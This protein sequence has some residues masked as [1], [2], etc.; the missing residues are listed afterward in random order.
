MKCG[1]NMSSGNVPL[2]SRSEKVQQNENKNRPVVK[3]IL[4]I[5][6]IFF[7]CA[8]GYLTYLYV[9]YDNMLDD[10]TSGTEENVPAAHM[11]KSKPL[12]ILLLGLDSR[13]QTGLM[14][15]DVIMVASLNPDRKS[16]SIVSIPRDTYIKVEGYKGRKANAFYSTV[17][18]LERESAN[19]TEKTAADVEIKKIFGEFLNTEID[20]VT[21]INFDAFKE[22][23]NHLG[24]I[25]IDVDMD[26]RYVDPTDG[27]DINLTQGLQTLDGKQTLDFVRYRMSNR[28][29]APSSDFQRNER[30]QKVVSAIIDEVNLFTVFKLDGIFQSIGDNITTDIPKKQ[31]KSFI[32]TY[33][34]ISNQDIKY[35]AIEGTWASPFIYPDEAALEEAK[36]NL[37]EQLK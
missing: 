27:T 28:G 4:W 22:I 6:L 20:Y 33:A 1:V 9:T 2:P 21:V 34:G 12:T 29:T 3:V 19:S 32:S 35:K 26:M 37:Q 13:E 8:A 36:G 11:A 5:A 15:T 18:R 31:L 23:I 10:M 24:G 30:Q 14:N 25:E 17:L 7:L 16:A